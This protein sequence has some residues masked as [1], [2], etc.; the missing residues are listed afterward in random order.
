VKSNKGVGREVKDGADG[1]QQEPGSGREA[2][3][4]SS[5]FEKK[6]RLIYTPPFPLITKRGLDFF[7]VQRGHGASS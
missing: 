5:R 7:S 2:A 1:R 3:G 6:R 4:R